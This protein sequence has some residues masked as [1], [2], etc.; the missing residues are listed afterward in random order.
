M[1]LEAPRIAPDMPRQRR[2]TTRDLV[3]FPTSIERGEIRLDVR[4]IDVSARGF[5]ARCSDAR[6]VRGEAVSVWLPQCGLVQARVM[7][8]L[9]GCFGAQFMV[10][11]DPRTYPDILAALRAPAD[12]AQGALPG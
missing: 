3:D 11:I 8:G 4:L 10:P 2:E 6:F 5:H 12:K 1:T 7:W 9:R